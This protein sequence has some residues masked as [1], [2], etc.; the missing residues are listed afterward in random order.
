MLLFLAPCALAGSAGEEE[1]D[2]E[3]DARD[4]AEAL[5]ARER[6]PLDTV[7]AAYDE[8][9]SLPGVTPLA[10]RAMR[11]ARGNPLSPVDHRMSL[12]VRMR[13]ARTLGDTALPGYEGSMDRYG[14]IADAT[15]DNVD[16]H[17]RFAKDRGE[18]SPFDLALGSVR[19][20]DALDGVTVIAGDL[21]VSAGQGLLVGR[22]SGA[23]RGM[24]V[25]R[26]ARRVA[27]GVRPY[28]GSSEQARHRAVAATARIDA[29]TVAAW[30]GCTARDATV[31]S[32]GVFAT[33]RTSGAHRT[34]ADLAARGAVR[35]STFGTT[36]QWSTDDAAVGATVQ[37]V[38]FDRRW[39]FD[40]DTVTAAQGAS[41]HWR[42][43]I[44]GFDTYGECA[45]DGRG[46]LSGVAGLIHELASGGGVC[47]H[48][49]HLA[50]SP[51]FLHAA[52]FANRVGAPEDGVYCGARVP[53]SAKVTCSAYCDVARYPTVTDAFGL[54]ET[55]WSAMAAAV[56]RVSPRATITV[57]ASHGATPQEKTGT[58]TEGITATSLALAVRDRIRL[59][60]QW[61]RGAWRGRW[62]AE[63]VG[64]SHDTASHQVG[65]LAMLDASTSL[66]PTLVLNV[67]IAAFHSATYETRIYTLEGSVSGEYSNPALY[68]DGQ[69]LY[70]MLT[71]RPTPT[72][73]FE[74]KWSATVATTTSVMLEIQGSVRV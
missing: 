68:R 4:R 59:D 8:L 73:M 27:L 5:D 41:V 70:A 33:F 49:R 24:D 42:A 7:R 60:V 43:G 62:R 48:A 64:T 3:G 55:A 45:T 54:P 36:V 1:L 40:G 18:V 19:V 35:E 22:G 13:F 25:L 57:S 34:A 10:A 53:V 51:A 23:A 20:R 44:G 46:V 21:E 74:T 37:A 31:D 50:A 32:T 58:T 16:A 69:R 52:S 65:V 67:R 9:L 11:G 17:M 71:W 38:R 15:I 2:V 61:T 26:V 29:L 14:A 12:F 6:A 66:D 39:A 56:W 47:V 72:V 30:W 28:T 63:C